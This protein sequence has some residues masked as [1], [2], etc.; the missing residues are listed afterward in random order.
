MFDAQV[1]TAGFLPDF[2][3]ATAIRHRRWRDVQDF[4]TRHLMAVGGVGV[5]VAVLLIAF[6]L[7]YVVA[8][9]FYPAEIKRLAAYPAPGGVDTATLLYA[10]EEQ[11]EIGLRVTGD[12][13]AVFFR[14]ES[15]DEVNTFL[16]PGERHAG[17]TSFARGDPH[18]AAFAI[19][20]TDGTV[21]VGRHVYRVTYP[22]GTTRLI[23]PAIEYPLQH[24]PLVLDPLGN[25]LVRLAVES[26]EGQTTVLCLLYT[27][28]SPR[29]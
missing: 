11:R 24:S 4:L 14:T 22:E 17:I 12:G 7:L 18:Q 15:G 25:R 27:S 21:L 6:Y 5:I 29:D 10:M 2:N 16:L 23:T 26:D 19:G 9:M 13:R 1:T 28:P 20:F 8:P 3:S